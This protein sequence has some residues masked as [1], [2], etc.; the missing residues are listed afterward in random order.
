MK[1]DIDFISDTQIM[2]SK[3]E[4]PLCDNQVFVDKA[5]AFFFKCLMKYGE[6]Q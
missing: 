2:P 6:P 3:L 1:F 5:V 4:S